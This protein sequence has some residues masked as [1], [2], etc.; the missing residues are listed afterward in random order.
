MKVSQEQIN[1]I[2]SAEVVTQDDE[3]L[4]GTA[5]TLE[6][7]RVPVVQVSEITGAPEMLDGRVKTLHPK[8]HGGILADLAAHAVPALDRDWVV[9]NRDLA[10]T[11]A[12]ALAS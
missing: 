4:G 12:M 1:E 10:D 3:N 8:I 2:Y 5:R 7:A 6:E 11:R 9:T